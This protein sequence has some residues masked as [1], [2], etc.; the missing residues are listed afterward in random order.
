MIAL[1]MLA[2]TQVAPAPMPA[3][4]TGCWDHRDGERW[5]QE[6]WTEPR[7][8]QMMGSSRS[9]TGDRLRDWEF[10]RIERAP[11]GAIT[12]YGSP[13]GAP[14]HPF[15]ML[16]VTA[17]SAEFVDPTHDYPQRILYERKGDDLSAEVSLK[18]GTKP[19]R[20]AYRRSGSP[21]P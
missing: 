19:M 11:D 4:L 6:C 20:W 2:A 5:T 16:M 8:G 3:F 10:M 1:L 15:K 14:A 17:T 9:G 21:A 18:D 13:R 7:A 12:F